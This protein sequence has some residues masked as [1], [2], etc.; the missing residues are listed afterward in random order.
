MGLNI[1]LGTLVGSAGEG[2]AILNGHYLGPPASLSRSWQML[3]SPQEFL[4]D[5]VSALVAIAQAWLQDHPLLAWLLYHPLISLGLLAI[6]VLLL[7]SLFQAFVEITQQ[8]WV[9]LLKVP[10]HLG[11]WLL[12]GVYGV[13]VWGF[14]LIRSKVF[15]TTTSTPDSSSSTP[16]RLTTPAAESAPPSS[17]ALEPAP[18]ELEPQSSVEHRSEESL[19][20][21]LEKTLES[22]LESPFADAEMVRLLHRLEELGQEQTQI[23]RQIARLAEAQHPAPTPKFQRSLESE[24]LHG[25]SP[26]QS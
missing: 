2:I 10:L 21:S 13:L 8:F 11:R 5:W 14:T 20:K 23:L 16:D 9:R 3:S 24:P 6:A 18:G 1:L 15:G 19:E 26:M 12:R 25:R 4:N 17:I 7:W 22:R